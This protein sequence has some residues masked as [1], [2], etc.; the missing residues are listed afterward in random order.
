VTKPIPKRDQRPDVSPLY[1]RWLETGEP[2]YLRYLTK[3]RPEVEALWA[4]HGPAVIERHIAEHPG[5]R[6]ANFWRYDQPDFNPHTETAFDFLLR[7]GLM[8]EDEE[9]R[10]RARRRARTH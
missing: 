1:Q 9:Q 5:T 7:R 4:K 10:A 3:T 8:S 6:P 2:A